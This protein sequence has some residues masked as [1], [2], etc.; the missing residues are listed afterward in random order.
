MNTLAGNERLS[1]YCYGPAQ[2]QKLIVQD[3]ELVCAVKSDSGELLTLSIAY[4]E[5]MMGGPAPVERL[6]VTRGPM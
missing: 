4:I 1:L 2:V 6:L 5:K 3:N